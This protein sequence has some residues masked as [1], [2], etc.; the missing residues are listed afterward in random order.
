MVSL[1]SWTW[2]LLQVIAMALSEGTLAHAGAVEEDLGE[3]TRS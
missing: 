2:G 3:E 1:Q